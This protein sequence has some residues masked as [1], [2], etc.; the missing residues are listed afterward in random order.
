MARDAEIAVKKPFHYQRETGASENHRAAE[1][2]FEISR[3]FEADFFAVKE[4]TGRSLMSL[5]GAKERIPTR[6][7]KKPE[8]ARQVKW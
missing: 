8:D 1:P 6:R 4:G 7:T 3:G 5:Q 2:K